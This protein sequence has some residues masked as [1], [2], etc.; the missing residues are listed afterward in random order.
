MTRAGLREGVFFAPRLF[1]VA[2]VPLLPDVRKASVRDLAIVHG[3]SLPH[4]EHVARLALQLHDSLAEARVIA[5]SVDAREL[6]FAAAMLHDLGM[7]I[8]YDDHEGHSHYLILGA[9]LPGFDPRG[10]ALIAQIVRYHRKGTPDLD[11][12]R[13]FARR[14]DRELVQRCALLLRLAELLEIGEEQLVREARLV[15]DGGSVE[16]RLEGD[17]HLA[18]WNVRRQLGDEAFRRVFGHRL[19]L[20]H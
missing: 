6:L 5:A 2:G 8:G 3:A 7:A 17:G 20:P 19:L 18:L 14:A 10:L 11:D 15:R 9:G 12:L 4:A 1:A 13:P 16:L